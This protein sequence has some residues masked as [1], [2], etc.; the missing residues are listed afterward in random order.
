[1]AGN[2]V[3]K[4]TARAGYRTSAPKTRMLDGKIVKPVLYAGRH[5]GHGTYMAGAIEGELVLDKNGKPLPFKSIG[6]L[7]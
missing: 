5:E 6:I 1:M 2:P 3:A 4:A 7:S